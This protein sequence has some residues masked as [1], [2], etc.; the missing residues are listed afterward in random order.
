MQNIN[1]IQDDLKNNYTPITT[2]DSFS[3]QTTNRID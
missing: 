2:M 1:E 3:A